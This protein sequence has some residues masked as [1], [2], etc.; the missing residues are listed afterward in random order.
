MFVTSLMVPLLDRDV[1]G[2]ALRWWCMYSTT[3]ANNKN[4]LPS[5]FSG[6][7]DTVTIVNMLWYPRRTKFDVSLVVIKNTHD[8]GYTLHYHCFNQQSWLGF[9]K[10]RI[11]PA[12]IMTQMVYCLGASLVHVLMFF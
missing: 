7:L 2:D 6:S 8:L 9:R 5:S 10:K 1:M 4:V 12:T 3:G 11:S